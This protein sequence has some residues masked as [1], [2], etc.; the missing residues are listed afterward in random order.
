M[1]KIKYLF[2][3]LLFS[4]SMYQNQDWLDF[5]I[6]QY[7]K[8]Q[9]FKTITQILYPFY[10]VILSKGVFDIILQFNKTVCKS[11]FVVSINAILLLDNVVIQGS[12]IVAI[13]NEL[14]SKF[15]SVPS[16]LKTCITSPAE[17][18]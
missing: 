4:C 6:P 7:I 5:E 2:I 1:K 15:Q 11:A 13:E 9:N 16:N 17:S 18:I 14:L 3:L 12:P 8:D 10:Y